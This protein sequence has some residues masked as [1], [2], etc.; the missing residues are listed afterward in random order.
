METKKVAPTTVAVHSIKTSLSTINKAVGVV[1]N[2]I[3]EEIQKQKI[4]STAP[5]IWHYIDC[6]GQMDTEFN[7][8]ICVPVA[9][10]GK[11]NDLISFKELSA[12]KCITDMHHGPWSELGAAY[13]KLFAELA[14]QGFKPSGQCR[15]VYHHCDFEDQSKCITEIQVEVL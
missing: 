12:F 14:Q 8:D 2:M 7:L 10:A 3:M 4:Q 9:E 15:E 5:Q 6:D 1:P 11:E 13:E